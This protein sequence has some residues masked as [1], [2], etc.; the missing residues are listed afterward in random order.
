MESSSLVMVD[1]WEA[2]QPGYQRSLHELERVQTMLQNAFR[3]QAPVGDSD[4]QQVSK[5]SLGC[6][7]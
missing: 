5:G 2:A 6:R 3:N 1:T 7:I 4:V